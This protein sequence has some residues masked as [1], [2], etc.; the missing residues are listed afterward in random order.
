[1]S[2]IMVYTKCVLIRSIVLVWIQRHLI[3]VI[4]DKIKHNDYQL[5]E[6]FQEYVLIKVVQVLFSL[7]RDDV[8][9]NWVI[10]MSVYYTKK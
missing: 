6:Y 1:M 10:L 4:L 9:V 8:L 2:I 5:H 7:L 3:Y